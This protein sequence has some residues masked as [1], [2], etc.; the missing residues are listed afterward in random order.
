MSFEH[1]KSLGQNFLKDQNIINK[2]NESINPKKNDL[3]I[4]IGPGMGV[5]TKNLINKNCDV[6]CFEI[7]ERLKTILS[8]I[9]ADNLKIEFK[10]FL[11]V[12][13]KDYDFNKYDN[14]YFIG[15]LPYYI[16]TSIINKI[17]KET[18]P[19]EIVIMI[20]KEVAERY[21]AKPCTKEYSSISVFL[22]YNFDIE[23]VCSVSKN[24]F[25][26][27]PKV[28]SMVVKLK[29]KNNNKAINEE[30]FYKIV[31]D[32]FKQKRKN[33]RNNLKNYDLLK[34]EKILNNYNKD[35]T[36]RAEQISIEEFIDI[37]NN[38]L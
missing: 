2:I 36:F 26:P 10:D 3:I 37:A 25:D 28:D 17:V 20:Q 29:K 24:C 4:E 34:I 33:L 7:D 5:L 22:Q 14:L 31:R 1:K 8:N 32:S 6:I 38:L 12:N 21:M 23:K 11:K 30:L 15:N 9:K 18:N 35:L 27:V 13:F 19:Y 16:T